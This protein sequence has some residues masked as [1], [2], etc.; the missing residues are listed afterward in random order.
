M[1]ARK[2]GFSE[3]DATNYQRRT[4]GT[5]FLRHFSDNLDR[6]SILAAAPGDVMLFRDDAYPCH[7]AIVAERDKALTIVHAHA[8]RR[9]VVE[10]E[11]DQGDWRT[12]QVACFA[13]IGID[14]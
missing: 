10:D 12:K 9:K 4:T 8:P 5:L 1:V 3:Y 7:A 2:L 6:K 11:L 13:F 14:D